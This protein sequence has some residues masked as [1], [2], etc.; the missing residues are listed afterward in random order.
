[1]K[2]T[3]EQ[4]WKAMDKET[5][6]FTRALTKVFPVRAIKRGELVWRK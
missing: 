2:A 1:M 6:A 4:I 5:Q 3:N